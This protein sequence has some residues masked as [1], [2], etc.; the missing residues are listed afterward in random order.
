[1]RSKRQQGFIALFILLVFIFPACV[2]KPE[3]KPDESNQP[4]LSA[5]D[6][7]FNPPPEDN[8]YKYYIGSG[9][10]KSGNEKEA[11]DIAIGDLI[12]TI[13]MYIGVEVSSETTA[14][15]RASVDDFQT[16]ISSVVKTTGEAKFSGFEIMEKLPHQRDD[17]SITIYLLC[18]YNKAELEK[19]KRRIQAAFEERYEAISVPEQEGQ[20]LVHQNKHYSAAIKFIEAA[21]AASTANVTNAEVK[22]ERN[23]NQAK[24]AVENIGLYPITK[25]I[26]T[27]VG[28]PFI[29]TFQ[30]KVVNGNSESS[31]GVSDAVLSISYPIIDRVGKKKFRNKMQKSDNQGIV[32]FDHP[33][34]EFVGNEKITMSLDM[35]AYLEQLWD[36]PGE[37][38]EMVAGLEELV[39][40]KRAIIEYKVISNANKIATGIVMLDINESGEDLPNSLSGSSI[41]S[42]LSRF[43]FKIQNL[44]IKPRA[45]K[46]KGD[47]EIIENLKQ[48]FSSRVRRAI[49]GT[50]RILSFGEVAGRVSARASATVQVVDLE[51]EEILL[52]VV[53]NLNGIGT[54]ED[55]AK[56]DAFRKLGE[57]VGEEIKNRLR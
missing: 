40:N 36:V 32:H 8:K 57:A 50:S 5:P 23:I 49:F 55:G 7:F 16:N 19:E 31:P 43:K 53:K 13:F 11:E 6:W 28:E 25:D 4:S 41:L 42:T 3:P 20:R 39:A 14:E 9:S 33:I 22:F 21:A 54:N 56:K 38:D 44:P 18:R 34:P 24:E 29:D 2:S 17:G 52:T 1:M 12:N 47:Y 48:N 37:F 30:L 46:D 35:D 27:I 51:N 15:A 26:E 10:S 45:I